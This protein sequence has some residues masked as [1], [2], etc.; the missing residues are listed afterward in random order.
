LAGVALSLIMQA[1]ESRANRQQIRRTFHNDLILKSVDDPELLECWGLTELNLTPGER[2]QFA[3]TNL[4]FS[5]WRME[6]ETG[7][8]TEAGLRNAAAQVFSGAPARRYWA[9]SFFSDP[10][11]FE[12]KRIGETFSAI[13]NDEYMKSAS[14]QDSF[15]SSNQLAKTP[16]ESG[17][18]SSGEQPSKGSQTNPDS[19]PSS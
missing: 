15:S 10:S 9:D 5:F 6:F 19:P 2:R 12:G 11:N 14:K 7:E 13:L 17:A 4:I 16:T 8:M 18:D 3:F 1:R